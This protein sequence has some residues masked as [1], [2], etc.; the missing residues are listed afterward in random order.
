MKAI[1]GIKITM[2]FYHIKESDEVQIEANDLIY[3]EINP[4]GYGLQVNNEANREEIKQLCFD[5]SKNVKELNK[6]IK[7]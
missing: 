2:P 7:Q 3:S 6:L 1:I 5:I 4:V